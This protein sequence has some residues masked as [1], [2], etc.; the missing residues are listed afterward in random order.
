MAQKKKK[1][2][3]NIKRLV[4]FLLFIYL[5]IY[6]VKRVVNEPIRNIIIT[7]NYY[8]SDNDI[9]ENAGIKNYPAMAKLNIS[10]IKNEL[11]NNPLISEVD[12]KR[13]LKF[14]LKIKIKELKVICL[15][16]ANNIIL[17]EDGSKIPNTN[18]FIGIP[19]LIN[20]T[21]EDVLEKFLNG[22]GNLDYGTLSAI[23]EIEYAPSISNDNNVV[24][25]TR[26]LLKMNDG[27]LVYINIFKLNNLKYYQ[28]IYA[29]LEDKQGIL[30]LD[31]GS[32][33]EELK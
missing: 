13:N 16:R 33:L 4:V 27:N 1:K 9:I 29:S 32:Y 14:Q 5:M 7:G 3:L 21:K 6:G 28:K 26:F 30:H 8:V 25:D 31:S 20:Y 10:K 12:I 17:L 15:D 2:R 22:M 11:L 23:S 18:E 24:D 19:T